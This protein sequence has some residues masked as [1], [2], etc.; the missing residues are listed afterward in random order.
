MRAEMADGCTNLALLERDWR[1][2]ARGREGLCARQLLLGERRWACLLPWTSCPQGEWPLALPGQL[3]LGLS[4]AV[5]GVT[6]RAW[7]WCEPA[8]PEELADLKPGGLNSWFPWQQWDK[9]T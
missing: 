8:A 7:Q 5:T 6:W 9:C 3:C 4:L 1:M 2:P